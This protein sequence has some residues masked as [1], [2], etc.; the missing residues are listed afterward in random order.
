MFKFEYT[1]PL[2]LT[3]RGRYPSITVTLESSADLLA[4][5]QAFD[6]YL[7]AAGFNY[8]GYLDLVDYPT[9]QQDFSPEE[10]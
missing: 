3:D 6:T 10:N 9:E 4:V 2:E 1:P 8:P 7:R 5:I